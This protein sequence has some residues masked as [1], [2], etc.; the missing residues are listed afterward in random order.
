MTKKKRRMTPDEV[1]QYVTELHAEKKTKDGK[2]AALWEKLA[3]RVIEKISR[4]Q[5]KPL[6]EDRIQVS[7]FVPLPYIRLNGYGY[8]KGVF[9]APLK[10]RGYRVIYCG[11][12][13]FTVLFD[14]EISG[15]RK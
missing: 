12:D 15:G 9:E 11:F 14:I 1:R 8:D 5:F 7:I 2:T 3:Y 10:E 4:G 6:D 13:L